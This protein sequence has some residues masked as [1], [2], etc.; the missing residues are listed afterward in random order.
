MVTMESGLA[1]EANVIC[2]NSLSATPI[3]YS[4]RLR[5]HNL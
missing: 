5:K 1:Y 2:W 3:Y 4:K